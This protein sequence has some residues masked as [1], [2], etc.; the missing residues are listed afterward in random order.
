VTRRHQSSH[1][2]EKSIKTTL[3]NTGSHKESIKLFDS[4]FKAMSLAVAWA[5]KLEG[6]PTSARALSAVTG[7]CVPSAAIADVTA[8]IGTLA[9]VSDNKIHELKT[10]LVYIRIMVRDFAF[11][12]VQCPML[13]SNHSPRHKLVLF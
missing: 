3:N 1:T 12:R 7:S 9:Q 13:R 8:N 4:K 10:P 11:Y 6:G 5:G 2:I